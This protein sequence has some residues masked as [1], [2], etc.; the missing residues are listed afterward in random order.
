MKVMFTLTA[1]LIATIS[2]PAFA[3]WDMG[4]SNSLNTQQFEAASP[5]APIAVAN[6]G[7]GMQY[8]I[9]TLD[10]NAA[11]AQA[12]QA[13]YFAQ[14]AYQQEQLQHQR[15]A[16][17]AR[18][19]VYRQPNLPV[20]QTALMTPGGLPQTSLDSFVVNAGGNADA[21]YGDE[22][23]DDIPP[24][25]GFDSSHTINAGINSNLTTGHA[26]NLPGAWTTY[27]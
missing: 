20:T 2:T 25:F 19:N 18:T 1:L 21:I 22:G 13:A 12:A 26:S 14:L 5:V 15:N 16:Y 17:N 23:T 7:G 6:N 3:D 10:N 27:E 9:Q 8:D 24:F 11:A 4:S